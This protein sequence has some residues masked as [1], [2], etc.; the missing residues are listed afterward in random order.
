M[1]KRPLL[2]AAALLGLGLAASAAPAL[3]A[4]VASCTDDVHQNPADPGQNISQIDEDAT[5]II[6][7]LRA[8]GVNV[9]DISDWGGC[10]RADVVKPD[11]STI[12]EFFDPNSLQRLS[13]G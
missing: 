9:T 1:T 6:A 3:A 11:G 12:F 10:V 13:R 4:S 5:S 8:K 2:L 7:G